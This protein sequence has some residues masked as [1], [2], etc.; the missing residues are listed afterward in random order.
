[1]VINMMFTIEYVVGVGTTTF[2]LGAMV[3]IGLMACLAINESE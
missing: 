1:M 2:V 3:G